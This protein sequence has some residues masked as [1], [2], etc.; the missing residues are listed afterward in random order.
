M[1][2]YKRKILSEEMHYRN[3]IRANVMAC[4]NY[5]LWLIIIVIIIT[6]TCDLQPS[7][8]TAN[9]L[10]LPYQLVSTQ[11]RNRGPNCFKFIMVLIMPSIK[12][13]MNR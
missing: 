1:I 13:C 11:I 3:Y 2:H 8:A 4:N 10:A 9:Q 12:H 5:S 7:T 6:S